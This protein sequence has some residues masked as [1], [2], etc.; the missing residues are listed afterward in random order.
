MDG[1][2]YIFSRPCG[3]FYIFSFVHIIIL[4]RPLGNAAVWTKLWVVCEVRRGLYLDKAYIYGTIYPSYNVVFRKR[5]RIRSHP[6]HVNWSYGILCCAKSPISFYNMWMS[7][8]AAKRT[9]VR[10]IRRNSRCVLLILGHGGGRQEGGRRWAGRGGDS[11]FSPR[12]G[13]A[14]FAPGGGKGTVKLL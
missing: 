13:E 6:N 14:I 11:D 10:R 1:F 2:L 8:E 3:I 12:G 4:V 9:I 5:S 7:Q